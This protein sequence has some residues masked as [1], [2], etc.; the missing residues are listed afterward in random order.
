MFSLHICFSFLCLLSR[1]RHDNMHL[2]TCVL[3]I[4]SCSSFRT[5]LGTI[6][7]LQ[8]TSPSVLLT[9]PSM[10]ATCFLLTHR[11]AGLITSRFSFILLVQDVAAKIIFHVH[12]GVCSSPSTFFE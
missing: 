11:T 1:W 12:S 9:E 3:A 8:I 7:F 4:F 10:I 2:R 5:K 6:P